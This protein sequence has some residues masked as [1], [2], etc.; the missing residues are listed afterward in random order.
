MFG[1][2]LKSGFSFNVTNEGE[3]FCKEIIEEMVNNFGLTESEA[4]G[5]INK[6]WI[7]WDFD[8]KEEIRYHDL[9]KDWAYMIY[10]GRDSHWWNRLDEPTLEPI[11]YP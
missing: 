4:L 1:I 8:S 11:P 10:Y 7:N 6:L 5:R 2:N 9:P 3:D